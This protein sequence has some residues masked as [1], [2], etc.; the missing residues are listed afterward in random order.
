MYLN[1]FLLYLL[2]FLLRF[3]FLLIHL[4]RL[5]NNWYN[6]FLRL[7][8]SC[9]IYWLCHIYLN[10]LSFIEID[11]SMNNG[12][13]WLLKTRLIFNRQRFRVLLNFFSLIDID[14]FINFYRLTYCKYLNRLTWNR[15]LNRL[16]KFLLN[17]IWFQ[18]F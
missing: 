11:L 4:L 18:I 6:K 2:N 7:F 3:L 14:W 15:F 16:S 10:L 12:R 8:R 5:L 1:N 9:F 17:L 13:R